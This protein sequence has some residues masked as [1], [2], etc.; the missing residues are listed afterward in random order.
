MDPAIGDL[1]SGDVLVDG[2]RIAAVGPH[3]SVQADR[4]IDA[5]GAIVI[6]GLINAHIHTW[7]TATRGIGSDWAGSDYFDFFHARLAPLYTPD[8][9]FIATLI[10]SLGQLDGGVTTILDWC[11]NNAT[12]EH[13]DAAVQALFDSGIRAVFGHGTV[14]AHAG[15]G[16]LHFSQVPHPVNEIARLRK[17]RLSSDDALVTL[18]MAILGPDYSTLEVCRHDFRAAREFGL[19]STA[20][21]W[22]RSNRLVPAGYRTLAAE[23]LLGP[24]HNVAHGNYFEDDELKI[25]VD[26]GVSLTSTTTG[27][28]QNHVRASLS[29][30]VRD[31]GGKPSIGVD[32]EVG[33]RGDMFSAM[34]ASLHMQRLMANQETVRQIESAQNTEGAAYVQKNLKTIGTGGSPI[35][36]VAF[37][38]REVLEWATINNARALGLEK[39]V[40]SLTPGK[41]ADIVL[42]RTDGLQ[43]V[44]VQDP[45]QAV[46]SY[47]QPADVDTVL[48]AGKVIKEHGKLQHHGLAR[49][50]DALRASGRRLLEA[51]AISPAA[52]HH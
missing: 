28:M 47:A 18:A 14:K 24:D 39:R 21:V 43:M 26:C 44:S 49:Q 4:T 29:G 30:R 5:A 34:R 23:G 33:S 6:P 35:K 51:A 12:P 9:T 15:P 10:G 50:L 31:L 37:K 40:G 32:S 36:Q 52:V 45:V 7:E 3:L 13:S 46:V 27:E 8:D 42:L 17:G 2:D 22:G 20:H 25:L 48:V 38:T 16:K 1:A 41:Q 19:L 11:H